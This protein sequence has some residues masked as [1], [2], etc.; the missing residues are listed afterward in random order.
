MVGS[1]G[2]SRRKRNPLSFEERR[3]MISDCFPDLEVLPLEDED[4]GEV[5]YRDW[6]EKFMEKA[7]QDVVI[8]RNDL[9]QGLVRKYS[10]AEIK[11]QQLF[12]PGKC[13]GT[14][15]RQKIRNNEKWRQ[16]VPDC[17]ESRIED[18]RDIIAETGG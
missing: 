16:L 2:K 3:K 17:C 14:K 11:E 12:M 10:D 9:V 4:R 6:T 15:I 13:S 5:G 18:C 1:A 8:T 7:E